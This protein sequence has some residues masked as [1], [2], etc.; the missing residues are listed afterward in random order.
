[1]SERGIEVGDLVMVVHS[2]CAREFMV[3]RKGAGIIWTVGSFDE[4]NVYCANCGHRG[5]FRRAV[6]TNPTG[7]GDCA[8]VPWLKRIPPLVEPESTTQTDEVT[9]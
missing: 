3:L 4:C 2:C 5:H 8:P 6:S 1:M 9:V 7:I